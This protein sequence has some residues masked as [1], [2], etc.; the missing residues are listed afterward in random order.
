M[1]TSLEWHWFLKVLC[2]LA[3]V[4]VWGQNGSLRWKRLVLLFTLSHGVRLQPEWNQIAARCAAPLKVKQSGNQQKRLPPVRRSALCCCALIAEALNKLI[5]DPHFLLNR[6]Y[7]SIR[8]MSP[9]GITMTCRNTCTRSVCFTSFK[10]ITL[11]CFYI[12]QLFW[13]LLMWK[14]LFRGGQLGRFLALLCSTRSIPDHLTPHLW[15]QG[16]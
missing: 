2:D 1:L 5:Q 16:W 9:L 6:K 15:H 4:F 7:C 14:C 11:M 10:S 3:W 12:L 13:G 8:L